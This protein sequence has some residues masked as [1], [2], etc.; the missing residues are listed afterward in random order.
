MVSLKILTLFGSDE[1]KEENMR[2]GSSQK[3]YTGGMENVIQSI[4]K[5]GLCM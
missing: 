4:E 2:N 3:V 1:L 5:S